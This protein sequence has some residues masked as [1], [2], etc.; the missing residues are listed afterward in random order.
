MEKKIGEIKNELQAAGES[1]LPVFVE[2]YRKDERSGVQAL[3]AKARKQIDAFAK[4]RQRIELMKRYEK[5]YASAGF[6]CGIDEVGRGP[7]QDLLWREQS[8]FRRIVRFFI[9][10]I[11][12]S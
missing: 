1:G 12:N 9:S 11:P 5:E 7:W 3:V 6:I 8:S 4:E 10:M 2:T